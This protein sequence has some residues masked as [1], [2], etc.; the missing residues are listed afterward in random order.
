MD[1]TALRG[2]LMKP[3]GDDSSVVSETL[4]AN[5]KGFGLLIYLPRPF[6]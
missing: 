5:D 4:A 1:R 2:H 3:G 6:R